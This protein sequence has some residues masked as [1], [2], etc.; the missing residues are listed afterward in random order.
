MYSFG[1]MSLSLN[2]ENTYFT[3]IARRSEETGM[4]CFR[5]VPSHIDPVNHLVSGERFDHRLQK[6][7]K[8]QMPIPGIIYDRCFYGDDPHS[9]QCAAI[10]K[11]LKTRDDL[12]F[13]GYGL[14]DKWRLY[15]ILSASVL[16]PYVPLT[17]RVSGGRQVADFLTKHP[18]IILKPVTG[19]G[20]NGIYCLERTGNSITAATEKHR[21]YIKRE[22]SGDHHAISWT[23][24]L[25]K[26]KDYLMQPYLPLVDNQQ[27]PFDIRF[28]VQKDQDG[29]WKERGRG[30][31][32]GKEEGLLSNLAAGGEAAD[33]EKWTDSLDLKMKAFTLNDLA[34]IITA[35]PQVLENSFPRLFELGIDI[36][37]ARDSSLWV[38]DVNSKPGR[39]LI[40]EMDPAK[41]GDLYAAP[42]LFAKKLLNNSRKERNRENEKTISN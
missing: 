15:E 6:W 27:R 12:L 23:E 19:S 9:K 32:T 35:L 24:Q 1:L 37:I 13:L 8:D 21:Q 17:E 41:A 42:L 4:T 40:L 38:L 10:V 3:E 22:F 30:I 29:A 39:K 34:E 31:R 11:W 18:K 36:G 25:I 2:S 5:F 14:P 20:G 33:F 7:R 28:L 26:K 16:A